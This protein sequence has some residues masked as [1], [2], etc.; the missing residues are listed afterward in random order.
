MMNI[1]KEFLMEA[2]GL[3]LLVALILIGMRMFQKTIKIT[4]Q[5]E[6]NQEQTIT[7]LEEYELVKY[8]EMV[9]DGM[10]ALGYI[11]N[12]I[13]EYSLPVIVEE[14][15]RKFSVDSRDDLGLLR[16]ADSGKYISPYGFYQCR[17]V[18]NENEVIYEINLLRE[19]E[20]E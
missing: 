14:K 5:I 1:S 15:Q 19:Q 4:T 11:K 2:V 16:N 9:I 7:Y 18:R 20:G 17:V 10:T 3:S 8:D 13:M 6:R 12:V